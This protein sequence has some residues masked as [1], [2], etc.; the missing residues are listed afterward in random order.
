MEPGTV[1]RGPLPPRAPSEP[2]PGSGKLG[3]NYSLEQGQRHGKVAAPAPAGREGT[4]VLQRF[5]RCLPAPLP[6]Y[7]GEDAGRY[8]D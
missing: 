5:R 7:A 8:L 3:G 2:Q 1:R 6:A 4:A